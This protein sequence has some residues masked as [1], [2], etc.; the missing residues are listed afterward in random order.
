[1]LNPKGL[2]NFE[3]SALQGAGVFETLKGI[4]KATLIMLRRRAL[5]EDKMKIPE[6]ATKPMPEKPKV[7]TPGPIPPVIQTPSPQPVFSE[8]PV[9]NP[10]PEPSTVNAAASAGAAVAPAVLPTAAEIAKETVEFSQVTTSVPKADVKKITVKSTDVG[11]KLDALRDLYT[12]KQKDKKPKGMK[13]P[14]A[15]LLG[16][17]SAKEESPADVTKKLKIRLEPAEIEVLQ[18]LSV[19]FH[20]TGG[21]IHK[22]FSNALN[23]QLEGKSNPKRVVLKIEI[24]ILKK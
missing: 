13:D 19:D 15:A 14:L 2:P 24:E 21:T 6:I 5:G 1:V 9:A 16:G 4:S 18:N 3:A 10:L 20:L 17:T 8:P 11:S 7:M 23:V 22:R 12:G